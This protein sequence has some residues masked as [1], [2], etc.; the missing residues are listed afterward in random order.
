MFV[1]VRMQF[2]KTYRHTT[3]ETFRQGSA[4]YIRYQILNVASAQEWDFT[5]QMLW[6][7][8]AVAHLKREQR[9][10]GSLPGLITMTVNLNRKLGYLSSHK[11][12]KIFQ[13]Q[14]LSKAFCHFLNVRLQTNIQVFFAKAQLQT[15]KWNNT[16]IYCKTTGG[17]PS[18]IW[19]FPRVK[20]MLFIPCKSMQC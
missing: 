18:Q 8:C 15:T 17:V 16:K 4:M 13:R 5:A 12:I 10:P 20:T 14:I 3:G 2:H 6:W 7:F 19:P 9:S 11:K 1:L